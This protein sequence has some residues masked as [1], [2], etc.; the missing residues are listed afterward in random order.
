MPSC[1]CRRFGT[2]LDDRYSPSLPDRRPVFPGRVGPSME[3]AVPDDVAVA[4][5]G[6]IGRQCGENDHTIGVDPIDI[7]AARGQLSGRRCH[8][9]PA[10]VSRFRLGGPP[11]PARGVLSPARDGETAVHVAP[12]LFTRPDARGPVR[13]LVY[14]EFVQSGRPR[15]RCGPRRY[16]QF[17]VSLR[18]SR[19][20]SRS[21]GRGIFERDLRYS[22]E[23]TMRTSVR[24]TSETVDRPELTARVHGR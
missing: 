1:P 8:A 4:R 2:P 19:I 10:P 18:W 16:R 7:V 12:S 5:F 15:G 20:S 13:R 11:L 22:C 23:N 6:T 14:S 3:S 24:L 21:A 9:R 17:S